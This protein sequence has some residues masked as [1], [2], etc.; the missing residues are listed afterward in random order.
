MIEKEIKCLISL[1]EYK[2]LE[3]LFYWDAVFFR[4]IIIMMS[5]VEIIQTQLELEKRIISIIC[6]LKCDWKRKIHYI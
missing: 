5:K 4:I 1:R 2:L 3:K 6:K